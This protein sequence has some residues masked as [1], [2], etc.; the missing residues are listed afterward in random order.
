MEPVSVFVPLPLLPTP[1]TGEGL[2]KG[3]LWALRLHDTG[4]WRCETTVRRTGDDAG[5]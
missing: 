1:A 3:V 2:G 5:W 4:S